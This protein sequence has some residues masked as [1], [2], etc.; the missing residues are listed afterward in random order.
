MYIKKNMQKVICTSNSD[1]SCT[2]NIKVQNFI[3]FIPATHNI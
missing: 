1:G 2:S 3:I